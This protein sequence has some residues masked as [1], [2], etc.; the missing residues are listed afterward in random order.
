MKTRLAFRM[1][2]ACAIGTTAAMV[3]AGCSAFVDVDDKP[4]DAGIDRRDAAYDDYDDFDD[5]N[6][7]PSSYTDAGNNYY[8][9]QYAPNNGTCDINFPRQEV[10][11]CQNFNQTATTCAENPS[12]TSYPIN[13]PVQRQNALLTCQSGS[14]S[15]VVNCANGCT[16][17]PNG[18]PD[19]CDPCQGFQ[20]GDYCGS[21]FQG[22]SGEHARLRVRCQGG[23]A[24]DD[25]KPTACKN[26]CNPGSGQGQAFCN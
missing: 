19:K 25:P 12:I 20:D 1:I 7:P 24:I 18:F 22:W 23:R 11:G 2:L 17:L 9:D 5:F 14:V 10:Q 13:Q 15:C 6:T 4:K 21:Q 8:Y 16:S 26:S 3:G